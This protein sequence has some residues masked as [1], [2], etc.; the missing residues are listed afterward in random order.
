[1]PKT[2]IIIAGQHGDEPESLVLA[3]QLRRICQ[4]QRAGFTVEFHGLL[5][6]EGFARGIRQDGNG[7]DINRLWSETGN[8]N[9]N[10]STPCTAAW[11]RLGELRPQGKGR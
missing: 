8:A 11:E 10:G 7:R 5:N 6:P 3:Q 4:E 2:V 1:V 9:A